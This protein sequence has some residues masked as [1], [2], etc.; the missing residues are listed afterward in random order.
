MHGLIKYVH[1]IIFP[2]VAVAHNQDDLTETFFI[3]LLRG[4]GIKGLK[5]IP[6]MRQKHN[7]AI[8]VCNT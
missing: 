4:A 5:S 2:L 3:N 8:D 6:V 7:Q 1:I